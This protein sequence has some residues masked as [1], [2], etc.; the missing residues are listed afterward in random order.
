MA[1]PDP[2]AVEG[3]R[4]RC[5]LDPESQAWLTRLG[6]AGPEREAALREL[7]A[8][9]LN[10][11]RFVLARRRAQTS[12]FP[13]EGLEDLAV[14]AA[15]DALLAILSRLDEY[16]GESRFTTWAWKFAFFEASQALRRRNWMGREIPSEDA[17][18]SSLAREMSPELALEH[19]ELMTALTSG[20]ESALTAHQREVFV[21]LA[22]NS[23]PVDVLAERMQTTR[24]ALYKTLH[25]ARSRLR[26]HL[27]GA[28]GGLPG[29]R[30]A[31]TMAGNR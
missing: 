13:R 6:A 12:D 25:E 21:A 20:V 9:L 28:I 14:E 16:R 10:A 2:Q 1:V 18:W 19:Q 22:L 17:G 26:A 31:G 23:V 27:E 15:D 7:L 29:R 3:P 5:W 4:W 11:A 30:T 8:L 24:G